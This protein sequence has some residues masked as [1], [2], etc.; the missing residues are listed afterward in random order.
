M[1][2]DLS[3]EPVCLQVCE[4]SFQEEVSVMSEMQINTVHINEVNPLTAAVLNLAK[5]ACTKC[6]FQ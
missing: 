5:V 4:K 2:A 3:R 6:G 1:H